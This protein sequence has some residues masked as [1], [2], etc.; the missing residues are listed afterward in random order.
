MEFPSDVKFLDDI[1]L[2]IYRPEGRMNQNSVNKLI[3]IIDNLVTSMKEPF[4]RFFD[5][6]GLTEVELNYRY[7]IH[8]SLRRRLFYAGRP[9]VKSAIL[10]RHETIV[11]YAK[12]HAVLTQGSPIN[13]RVFAERDEVAKW[14]E[15]PSER[16][17]AGTA[18]D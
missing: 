15:V 2:L 11:H 17:M 16:L 13:V 14:L 8:V 5:G 12:L 4:N 1:R 18:A 3:T 6:L 10:A 7:M 9:P